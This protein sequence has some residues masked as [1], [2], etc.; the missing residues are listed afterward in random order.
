MSCKTSPISH[1]SPALAV[2]SLASNAAPRIIELTGLKH[3]YR[4]VYHE[5]GIS[6]CL[7]RSL[8]TPVVLVSQKST[9]TQRPYTNTISQH[10]QIWGISDQSTKAV[11]QTLTSFAQAFL[12]KAFPL[13]EADKAL[14]TSAENSSLT[15]P[16]SLTPN[17]HASYCLKTFAGFS[18]TRTGQRRC[19]V[20]KSL[21][22]WGMTF[23]GKCLTARILASHKIENASTLSDIL[24]ANPDPKYFL[25]PMQRRKRLTEIQTRQGMMAKD[26]RCAA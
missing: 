19:A 24:E 1:S 20:S 10:T 16:A 8:K 5:Q 9:S 12:A 22:T 4:C 11:C 23:N 2:S 6:C 18:L 17:T 15:W 25:S 26:L 14:A 13:Q 7:T 3:P 21:M